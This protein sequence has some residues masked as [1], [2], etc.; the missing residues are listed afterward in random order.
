VE[1]K[2]QNRRRF[3]LNAIAG[4]RS[5]G[6][7]WVYIVEA[8]HPDGDLVGHSDAAAKQYRSMFE[9][10]SN[11]D[12]RRC[13]R[14][15]GCVKLPEA[16]LPERAPLLVRTDGTLRQVSALKVWLGLEPFAVDDPKWNGHFGQLVMRLHRK[17]VQLSA[18]WSQE[19]WEHTQRTMFLTLSA[20]QQARLQAVGFDLAAPQEVVERR[21]AARGRSGTAELVSLDMLT[22]G[23]KS[24]IFKARRMIEN[25]QPLPRVLEK[26]REIAMATPRKRRRAA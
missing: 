19:Q 6:A 18:T 25:N 10:V 11:V 5:G 13:A 9:S 7:G 12:V 17:G 21:R 24:Q 26:Y 8:V 3:L 23:E 20:V 15:G 16:K 22:G 2:L 4:G 1:Q 14:R